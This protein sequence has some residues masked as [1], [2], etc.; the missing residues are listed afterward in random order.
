MIH[1]SSSNVAT[2]N[3]HSFFICFSFALTK[4]KNN[5]IE[6]QVHFEMQSPALERFEEAKSAHKIIEIES[7]IRLRESD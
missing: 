5:K 7:K 6:K 3:S 2:T 4:G 1:E